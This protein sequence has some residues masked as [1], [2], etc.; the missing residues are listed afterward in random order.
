MI[1]PESRVLVIAVAR[2]GD[3]V[4]A[5]PVLRALAAAIPRGRL[6]VIV[7]A[8]RAGLLEGLP[9]VGRIV[10]A[11]KLGLAV[12]RLAGRRYDYAFVYGR[13]GW[14]VRHALAV[15]R[16]VIAF[17]QPEA[18][19]NERLY[20]AVEPPTGPIHAVR[21]R[22]LLLE[23]VGVPM[24]DPRAEYRV[25]PAEAA[26]AGRFIARA[27]ARR[28]HPL[29]ALAPKSFPTKAYR[30]WPQERF[31]ALL[32]RL[33]R[34]RP[35]AGAVVLGDAGARDVAEALGA[36][37]PGRVAA[38]AGARS[39]RESAALMAACDLYVGVDTGPTHLAGAL[40]LPMVALYHCRHRGRHLA[41]LGH[42]ALEVIEHPAADADCAETTPMA[43]IDADTVWQAVARR[44]AAAEAA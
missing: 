39:L 18:G 32:D 15:A 1:E 28:P 31:V 22:A 26:E 8:N 12:A 29:L 10:G 41:P 14:L 34:E 38:A 40:G 2:I 43:A 19:L 4:L 13:D 23:A 36:R 24:P 16:R 3:T 25:A 42:P 44:L 37:F 20:R 7:Q 35:A 27:F 6:D 11:R 21:E 33:F 5:T 30:D 9:Y 17:R